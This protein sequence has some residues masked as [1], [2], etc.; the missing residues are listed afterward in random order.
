MA[1][2]L[3]YVERLY[4]VPFAPALTQP[5]QEKNSA[6]GCRGIVRAQQ[7]LRTLRTQTGKVFGARM[8]HVSVQVA[9][10]DTRHAICILDAK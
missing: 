1:T 7:T 6:S 8:T 5:H 9:P 3:P 4:D 10:N 2:Q